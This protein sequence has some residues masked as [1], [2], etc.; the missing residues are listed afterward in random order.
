MEMGATKLTLRGKPQLAFLH[1]VLVLLALHMLDS[2]EPFSLLLVVSHRD[3]HPLPFPLGLG[4]FDPHFVVLKEVLR[5][6][7][8]KES[9]CREERAQAGGFNEPSFPAAV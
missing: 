6:L 8:D 3:Y 7:D 4:G 1:L 2:K 5:F 9:E